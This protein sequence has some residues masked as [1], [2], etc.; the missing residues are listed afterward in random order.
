MIHM[1]AVA[2]SSHIQPRP[3]F[4]RCWCAIRLTTPHEAGAEHQGVQ[5]VQLATCILDTPASNAKSRVLLEERGPVAK[6]LLDATFPRWRWAEHVL[7]RMD[8]MESTERAEG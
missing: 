2:N 4:K 7:E 3:R 1:W 5:T 8:S 6:D